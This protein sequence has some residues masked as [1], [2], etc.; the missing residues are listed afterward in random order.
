MSECCWGEMSVVCLEEGRLSDGGEAIDM[1]EASAL[2]PT[3]C[4]LRLTPAACGPHS[5]LH[6]FS[7]ML[8][9]CQLLLLAILLTIDLPESEVSE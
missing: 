3:E 7:S 2:S 5:P 8:I 6:P 9:C 1:Q 4:C